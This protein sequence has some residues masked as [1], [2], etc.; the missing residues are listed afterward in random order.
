MRNNFYTLITWVKVKKSYSYGYMMVRWL[1][2]AHNIVIFTWTK[3]VS[4]GKSYV[5]FCILVHACSLL[6]GISFTPSSLI[7]LVKVKK[8]KYSWLC[9]GGNFD[10][11][12]TLW[13][14]FRIISVKMVPRLYFILSYFSDPHHFCQS[15][16]SHSYGYGIVRFLWETFTILLVSAWIW[17]VSMLPRLYFAPFLYLIILEK[18][19]DNS[20]THGYVR[21]GLLTYFHNSFQE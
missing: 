20:N 2:N 5:V 7:T 3:W 9:V 13:L 11:F 14:F 19:D 4:I 18:D 10:K 16:I 12:L 6:W 8:F 15:Q 1:T 17:W 21:V